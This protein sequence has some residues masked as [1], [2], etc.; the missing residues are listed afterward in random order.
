MTFYYT[1]NL[2]CCECDCGN[3]SWIALC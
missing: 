3:S 2:P 1:D